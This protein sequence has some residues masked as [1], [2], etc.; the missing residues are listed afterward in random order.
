MK[1]RIM[2]RLKKAEQSNEFGDCPLFDILEDTKAGGIHPDIR[3][4]IDFL[5]DQ[6]IAYDSPVGKGLRS[7]SLEECYFPPSASVLGEI[8]TLWQ[9]LIENIHRY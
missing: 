3:A 1:L 9:E 7:L 6:E 2:A 4:V 8:E 5:R